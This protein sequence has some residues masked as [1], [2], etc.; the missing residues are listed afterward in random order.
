MK[1]K[2]NLISIW[3]ILLFQFITIS[4]VSAQTCYITRTGSKYHLESCRHLKYSKLA[5]DLEKAISKGYQKCK[6]CKPTSKTLKSNSSGIV[7][8]SSRPIIKDR[9]TTVQCS[10]LTKKGRRC[11]NRT[12][13]C[14]G[15]CHHHR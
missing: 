2:T 15:R 12:K 6:V 4:Y 13:N 5:I 10:G 9:C 11:R 14:S 3:I 1:I 7:S 8:G